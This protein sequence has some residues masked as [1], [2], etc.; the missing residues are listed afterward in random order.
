MGIEHELRGN[1]LQIID[2][3]APARRLA[4]LS[5]SLEN[6]AFIKWK[7]LFYA[8]TLSLLETQSRQSGVVGDCHD[9]TVQPVRYIYWQQ[10]T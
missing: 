3:A 7:D 8:P 2:T 10:F 9:I 1:I 6:R 4:V 5:Y